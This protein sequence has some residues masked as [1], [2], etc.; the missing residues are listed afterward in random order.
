MGL[1]GY[2]VNRSNTVSPLRRSAVNFSS[3]ELLGRKS[4][5]IPI[6]ATVL[7]KVQDTDW[8]FD[9]SEIVESCKSSA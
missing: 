6:T 9:R 1:G 8:D 5:V 3:V 7:N 2:G 4:A